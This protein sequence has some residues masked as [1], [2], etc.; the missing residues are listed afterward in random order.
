MTRRKLGLLLG[1]VLVIAVVINSA[2]SA[3]RG[4]ATVQPQVISDANLKALTT[5]I[6]DGA[7]PLPTTR[8]VPHWWGSTLDPNNGV[9]YGY[10]MVGADPNNCTGSACSVTVETDIT[11]LI[12]NVGGLH[13]QRKRRSRGNARLAAVRAQRLRLDTVRNRRCSEPAARPGR[14]ALT[15]RCRQSSSSYRTRRCGR[16]STRPAAAATT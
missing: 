5:T 7:N 2:A 8:T 15:E 16:S 3:A 9:T 1:V 11:P 13:L 10:N 12:V 6:G 14:P 4:T